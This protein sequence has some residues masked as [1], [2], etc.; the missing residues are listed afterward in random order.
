[1]AVLSVP[2]TAQNKPSCG[3]HATLYQSDGLANPVVRA[4]HVIPSGLVRTC[5]ATVP[6]DATATNNR[7]SGDQQMLRHW[8]AVDVC[9]RATQDRVQS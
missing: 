7:F 3:D 4:V 9:G 6:L 1:M 8:T 2:A 5:C